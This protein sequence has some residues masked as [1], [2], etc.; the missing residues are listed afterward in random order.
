MLASVHVW[1]PANVDDNYAR[2]HGG[3]ASIPFKDLWA[4]SLNFYGESDQVPGKPKN[5]AIREK[6]SKSHDIRTQLL[7]GRIKTLR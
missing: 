2:F 7:A 1:G 6:C 5:A 4:G 3:E